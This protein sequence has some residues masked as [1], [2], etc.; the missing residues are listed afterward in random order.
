VAAQR[1]SH[2][3]N[4][5]WGKNSNQSQGAE[6]GTG[7]SISTPPLS[8]LGGYTATFA[9]GFCRPRRSFGL[10]PSRARRNSHAHPEMST[11]EDMLHKLTF[12]NSNT[13]WE[14]VQSA[15]RDFILS[16][17]NSCKLWHT[18]LRSP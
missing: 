7:H 15:H 17:F 2:S 1:F 11:F 13:I 10:T 14:S 18:W 5:L 3:Q 16:T 9:R 12:A 8:T 6:R 4:L